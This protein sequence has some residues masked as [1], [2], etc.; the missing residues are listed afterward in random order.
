MS[1]FDVSSF[2]SFFR[3]HHPQV[4]TAL[5]ALLRSLHAGEESGVGRSRTEEAPIVR[6]LHGVLNLLDSIIENDG[7]VDGGTGAIASDPA[8]CRRTDT[9]EA[10]FGAPATNDD[11]S[12]L[13]TSAASPG[14]GV[15]VEPPPVEAPTSHTNAAP[16]ASTSGTP[17][18]G[19]QSVPDGHNNPAPM[20]ATEN[21]FAHAPNS[22]GRGVPLT[23]GPD[24]QQY[25]VTSVPDGATVINLRSIMAMRAYSSW[26]LEELRLADILGEF[27]RRNRIRNRNR[28]HNHTTGGN[29]SDN[30]SCY[31]SGSDGG[32]D[33]DGNGAMAVGLQSG[34]LDPSAEAPVMPVAGGSGSP[35]PN[36]SRVRIPS[37]PTPVAIA[38]SPPQPVRRVPDAQAPATPTITSPSTAADA[39]AANG[40]ANSSVRPI[41][42]ATL[43]TQGQTRVNA[44]G[45]SLQ[46]NTSHQRL[47]PRRA[48]R[49]NRV[50]NPDRTVATRTFGSN[51]Y[52]PG[53]QRNARRRQ[54]QETQHRRRQE[55]Q[56]GRREPVPANDSP[57][58]IDAVCNGMRN[59]DNEDSDHADAGAA[60]VAAAAA[61]V[62]VGGLTRGRRE[63]RDYSQYNV[64]ELQVML[65]GLVQANPN[66]TRTKSQIF[67]MKRAELIA[68]LRAYYRGAYDE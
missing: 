39:A 43:S 62:G 48:N 29:G 63:E 58:S 25:S 28:N 37:P 23:S 30:G 16:L 5:D 21:R 9:G 44:P 27:L 38:S 53:G 35:T 55:T 22:N 13:D 56:M 57:N 19:A 10:A 40:N 51:R 61:G 60:A 41:S 4:A 17:N 20:T 65:W 54:L 31:D 1:A 68:D 11:E 49:N 26:S 18:I 47:T 34:G 24:A 66:D 64:P 15:A 52:T 12:A 7:R 67:S 3:E 36:T 2:L 50:R 8:G 6:Q 45:S 42:T 33:G 59:N 32:N 14:A 46:S